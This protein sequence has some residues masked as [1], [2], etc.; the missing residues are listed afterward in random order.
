MRK[1]RRGPSEKATESALHCLA[2][3][4]Y[5]HQE[6]RQKLSRKGFTAGEIDEALK[7]LETRG[8]LD[9]LRYARRVALSLTK[10]KLFGPRRI[11]QKL[12]EKGI[13]AGLAREAIAEAEEAFPASER[14]RAVMR[15]KLKGQAP[16]EIPFKEKRQLTQFLL[17]RG[18]PWE[19]ISEAFQ[20]TAGVVEE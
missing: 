20:E 18:F 19:D 5:S 1:K 4:D 14:L 12:F 2:I 10:E 15:M 17:R 11:G 13:P 9:D 3:R 6:M 8:Y 16:E 7:G